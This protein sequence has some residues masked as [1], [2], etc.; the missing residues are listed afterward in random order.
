MSEKPSPFPNLKIDISGN[1][2]GHPGASEIIMEKANESRDKMDELQEKAN[3]DKLTGLPNQ[4]YIL[5]KLSE[6]DYQKDGPI[7]V[8]S[9]DVNNLKKTNDQIGHHIGDKLLQNVAKIIKGSLRPKDE[10]AR[11]GGD[12]F[13]GLLPIDKDYVEADVVKAI[14]KK[15]RQD[16]TEFNK[17]LN[18]QEKVNFAIGLTF[19]GP[20][21]NLTEAI[22]EAD[23]KM[24][25]NK[26][27]IKDEQAKQSPEQQSVQ[28]LHL[29][30]QE[31]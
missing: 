22:K 15:I 11:L 4:N 19:T 5:E 21:K 13:L 24:Y 27:K 2:F 16:Q 28:P 6:Y 17:K 9:V 12:E 30:E 31:G 1:N 8:L 25:Q 29:M 23:Q 3:I 20:D 26:N 18:D 10:F 14:S 7:C